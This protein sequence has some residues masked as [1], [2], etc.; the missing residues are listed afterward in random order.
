MI[1]KLE[2]VITSLQ[3]IQGELGK[4]LSGLEEVQF[5]NAIR[6]YNIGALMLDSHGP[7]MLYRHA[8]GRLSG[9]NQ[10]SNTYLKEILR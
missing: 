8:L 5:E 7:L 10:Y 2:A 3:E 4:S 6:A 9:A 1:K